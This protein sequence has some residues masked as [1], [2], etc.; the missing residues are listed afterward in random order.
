[1]GV[2]G[3]FIISVNFM[4]VPLT[5]VGQTSQTDIPIAGTTDF[6]V[7]EEVLFSE[8]DAEDISWILEAIPYPMPELLD[9]DPE[10]APSRGADEPVIG[11][12]VPG[13]LA[14]RSG[15]SSQVPHP[16]RFQD[17]AGAVGK[18]FFKRNG[19]PYVCSAQLVGA[20]DVIVTAGH[21]LYDDGARSTDIV[22]CPLYPEMVGGCNKGELAFT[23]SKWRNDRFFVWDYG[24]VKLEFPVLLGMSA[25]GYVAQPNFRNIQVDAFGY[26]AEGR[27]DGEILMQ[28]TGSTRILPTQSRYVQLRSDMNG[29]AS[30]GGWINN[31]RIIALNSYTRSDRPGV[32][33]SPYLGL[34]FCDMLFSAGVNCRR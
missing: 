12:P 8:V 2:V 15:V 34:D 16:D 5:A 26:P 1:M 22:F 20:F 3:R 11:E 14:P 10:D 31:N 27:F 13:A 24:V 30:G 4:I 23:H 28:V 19:Q 6:I 32:M 17:P 29:G 7:R 25:L 18:L 9:P 21:C 33:H